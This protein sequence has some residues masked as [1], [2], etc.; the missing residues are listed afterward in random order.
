MGKTQWPAAT[1]EMVPTAELV[2]YAR[3]ARKHPAEQI[4][5]IMQSITRYG[6][7]IPVLVDEERTLIA[8]HGRVIAARRLGIE[9]VPTM[10]ARGWS[11]EQKRAYA[12]ADNQIALNAEWDDEIL[13]GELRALE[14][15]GV[16]LVDVGFSQ[17]ELA[18]YLE[19]PAEAD[20]APAA[21]KEAN[22]AAVE[23]KI[24]P[25][26]AV[27]PRA[28]WVAW[29]AELYTAVGYYAPDIAAELLRR[30]GLAD[31]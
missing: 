23:L 16:P 25:F 30:L 22:V 24:G 21:P 2:P 13:R 28:K 19:M 12:L 4:R 20:E 29:E 18:R 6:W 26:S 10:T 11:A 5:Q 17:A 27:V 9:A 8:G 3:N 31:R 1:V 14:E 15:A 7:T